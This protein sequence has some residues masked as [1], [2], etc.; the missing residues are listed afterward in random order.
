MP[1]SMQLELVFSG[2]PE[3]KIIDIIELEVPGLHVKALTSS[4]YMFKELP[5]S[6]TLFEKRKLAC[7]RGEDEDSIEMSS[8]EVKR[9]TFGIL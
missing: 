2:L 8:E 3:G 4:S 6:K 9:D 1:S 5:F 7:K